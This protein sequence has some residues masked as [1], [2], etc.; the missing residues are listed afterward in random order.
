[1]MHSPETRMIR[2]GL[3]CSKSDAVPGPWPGNHILIYDSE[4]GGQEAGAHDFA[5]FPGVDRRMTFPCGVV[6]VNIHRMTGQGVVPD[7]LRPSPQMG[8]LIA[9]DVFFRRWPVKTE[10]GDWAGNPVRTRR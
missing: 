8:P 6:E 5:Q 3:P 4:I 2:S 10:I 7:Q 9:A 1:M